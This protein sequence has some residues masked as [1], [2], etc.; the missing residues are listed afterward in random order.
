MKA[1][2]MCMLVL[3]IATVGESAILE[4][5]SGYAYSTPQAA[6][7]ASVSG[8]EIVIH[9]GVY[10]KSWGDYVIYSNAD[11]NDT[12]RTNITI[13]SAG[14]G[15]VTFNGGIYL[16]ASSN[17]TMG[18]ISIENLYINFSGIN[19]GVYIRADNPKEMLGCTIRG[20]VIYSTS[21]GGQGIY[22][23]GDGINGEHVVEHN[24]IYGAGSSTGYGIREL[25]SDAN[26]GRTVPLIRDNIVVNTNKGFLS[27]YGGNS[28]EYS[29][30]WN[31][32]TN[33]TADNYGSSVYK[34]TG[35]IELD[36]IFA[37]TNPDD[38]TFLMLSLNTPTE[39]LTGAHDGTYMGALPQ[40]P[41]PCAFG[42]L[43]VFALC[44]IV[45]RKK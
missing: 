25:M 24:T 18:N 34:S 23:Y 2:M 1:L 8:D 22:F 32:G 28:I 29:D 17:G 43:F 6:W 13:R 38:S 4:V 10:N 12:P 42:T 27:W 37:S 41:E 15:R 44:Y 14:D 45:K 5:G 20:N 9:S 30:H 11:G 33:S 7:N 39:V 35:S 36:P 31:N 3:L 16:N 26:G 40:V 21:G 19:A